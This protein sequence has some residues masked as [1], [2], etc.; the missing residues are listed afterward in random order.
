M[1]MGLKIFKAIGEGIV[2]GEVIGEDKDTIF[3]KFPGKLLMFQSR[4]G[5]DVSFVDIVP[6][7]FADF[8]KLVEK[9]PLKRIHIAFMGDMDDKLLP[10]Y[11][12]YTQGLIQRITGI[13]IAGAD[14]LGNLPKDGKTGEPII[15]K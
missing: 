11:A 10:Y 6:T 2:A 13:T 12:D 9:F 1:S 8:K 5:S 7:F 4:E 14:A 3:L 15:P